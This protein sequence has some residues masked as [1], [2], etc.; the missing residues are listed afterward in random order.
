M[1]NLTIQKIIFALLLMLKPYDG[2]V[3]V[4]TTQERIERMSLL[5]TA[6]A[7]AT[8]ESLCNENKTI[9]CWKG[10]QLELASLLLAKGWSET[11][12]SRHIHENKCNTDECDPVFGTWFNRLTN[13]N[14]RYVTHFKA[15]S[16]WQLHKWSKISDDEWK[17]M[18][19]GINYASTY[20]SALVAARILS[21]TCN[22]CG[23][24]SG[25]I[26][27]YATGKTCKWSGAANRVYLYSHLLKLS[28]DSQ[29]LYST[30]LR[31]NTATIATN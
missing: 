22:R 20:T 3:K 29:L 12:F 7:D 21:F 1:F 11:R 26:S 9:D 15:R 4:E 28:A 18:A 17:S 25:G 2:D 24:I 8:A 19:G 10:S 14:V 16:H 5:A 23:S 13:S 30:L 27:L 31:Q 6:I